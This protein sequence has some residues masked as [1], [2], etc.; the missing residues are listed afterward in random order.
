MM[1]QPFDQKQQKEEPEVEYMNQKVQVSRI[2]MFLLTHLDQSQINEPDPDVILL[3]LQS[4]K[5][6][7][8][9]EI[10]SV[11]IIPPKL[12]TLIYEKVTF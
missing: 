8:E 12:V 11:K 6:N 9:F 3:K 1:S 2:K 5:L 4:L 10:V 7:A